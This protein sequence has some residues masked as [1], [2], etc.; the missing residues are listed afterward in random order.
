MLSKLATKNGVLLMRSS[1][2]KM[3]ALKFPAQADL[4]VQQKPFQK[5]VLSNVFSISSVNSKR[6]FSS[7]AAAEK[8]SGSI[9][10]NAEWMTETESKESLPE[11][12][13]SGE[14]MPMFDS[15]DSLGAFQSIVPKIGENLPT[16]KSTYGFWE[17]ISYID[18][19]VFDS[20]MAAS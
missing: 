16:G 13:Q 8:T 1:Q 14:I 3:S 12:T 18:T 4:T 5:P 15:A 19:L 10:D 20:W 2:S 11:S 17:S 7:Q 6:S 9:F